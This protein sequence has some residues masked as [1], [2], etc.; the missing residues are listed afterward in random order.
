MD[1][2]ASMF[3]TRVEIINDTQSSVLAQVKDGL[4][5][6]NIAKKPEAQSVVDYLLEQSIHEFSHLAVLALRANDPEQYLKLI[7]LITKD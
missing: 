1:R 5:V 7:Q 3:G 4:I 2:L 6:I